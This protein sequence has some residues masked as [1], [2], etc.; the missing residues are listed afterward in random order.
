MTS[1]SAPANHRRD[2]SYKVGRSKESSP[3]ARE[4]GGASAVKV[5]GPER[6][7]LRKKQ[8]ES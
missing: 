6:Q 8:E 5:E 7:H 2:G 4:T 3:G 1:A